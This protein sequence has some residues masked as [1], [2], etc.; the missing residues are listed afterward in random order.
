[1]TSYTPERLPLGTHIIV[2]PW[3]RREPQLLGD[4]RLLRSSASELVPPLGTAALGSHRTP[5]TI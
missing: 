5:S 1:M 3:A 2:R 4:F